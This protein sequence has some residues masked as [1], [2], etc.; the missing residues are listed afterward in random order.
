MGLLGKTVL[1]VL[2]TGSLAFHL[3]LV[4]ILCFAALAYSLGRRR[5]GAKKNANQVPASRNLTRLRMAVC[6]LS[7]LLTVIAAASGG[8][9]W[10]FAIVSLAV[11]IPWSSILGKLTSSTLVHVGDSTLLRSALFPLCWHSLAEV[12][13][14]SRPLPRALS[15]YEGRLI[16][17]GSGKIYCHVRAFAFDS[18][19]AEA[20]TLAALRQ[21]AAGMTADG[22]YLMPLDGGS[23]AK[24]LSSRLRRVRLSQRGLPDLGA[25][26]LVT[27]SRE[28]FL[29]RI[30]TYRLVG[31]SS[32]GSVPRTA[33]LRRRPLLWETLEAAAK[34]RRLP[35]PDSF[36]NL[37]ESF[38]AARGEPIGERLGALE[39]AGEK[40]TLES[41]SGDR[42]QV[43]RPQLRALAALYP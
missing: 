33:G 25:D 10:L 4:A 32:A 18:S 27:E 30:A 19:R 16:F 12:K 2:G 7:L 24:V 8:P 38:A 41:L 9:Y 34:V 42:L 14:G 40:V 17:T 20:R 36:S 15:S 1:F 3:W 43:T 13:P 35:E 6:G 22:A 11:C 5:G 39:D 29:T 28:G 21:A 31:S 26:V 37:L 23:A